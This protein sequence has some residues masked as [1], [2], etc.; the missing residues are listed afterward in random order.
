MRTRWTVSL[1]VLLAVTFFVP[2][3][4]A[5]APKAAT[6]PAGTVVEVRTD[7][8]ISIATAKP[9]DFFRA[10]LD[11]DILVEGKVL[12]RRGAHADIRLMKVREDRDE[13]AFRLVTLTI[14]GKK[15]KVMSDTAKEVARK[16]PA[17]QPGLGAA[18][19]Q[20]LGAPGGGMTWAAK[21]D[22][23]VPK[24]TVLEFTLREAV[25]LGK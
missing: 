21:Q 25:K 17:Q 6:I 12:V 18:L 19:G 22:A 11:E 8:Q 3:V 14:D 5:A 20:A 4:N 2:P 1:L 9:G 13:L 23:K 10:T 24:G 7:S 16:K 15:V